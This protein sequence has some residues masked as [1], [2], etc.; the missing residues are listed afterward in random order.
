MKSDISNEDVAKQL[1]MD[2][3]DVL[4]AWTFWEKTWR[5]QEKNQG[6]GKHVGLRC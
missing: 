4:K 1:E 6:F 3:E 5:N 2:I